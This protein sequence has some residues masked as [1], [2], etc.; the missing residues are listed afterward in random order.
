MF[1]SPEKIMEYVPV[2]DG[3][4]V[5]DLGSGAG[6]WAFLLAKRVNNS[7]KVYAIDVQKNW[8]VRLK[9]EAEK[10]KMDNIEV[11]W[12]D[13]EELGGTHLPDNSLDWVFL[14]NTLF[15]TERR[16]G[17][18]DETKR[19]LKPGGKVFL[20]DWKDSFGGIG[21]SSQFVIPPTEAEWLFLDK[22]FHKDKDFPAGDHHYG[23]IFSK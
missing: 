14:V 2:Y 1:L 21:P 16:D 19:I 15:S 7:G 4:K 12:G 17:A 9:H 8:L 22:G 3:M 18:V 20:V 13:I 6:H 11:V 10:F 23:M 5:A